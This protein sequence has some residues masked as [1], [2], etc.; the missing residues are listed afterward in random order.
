MLININGSTFEAKGGQTILA[1]AKANGIYIPTLCHDPKLKPASLCRICLVEVKGTSNWLPACSTLVK[2][3]M[4][5]QTESDKLLQYRRWLLGMTLSKIGCE[6]CGRDDP[7]SR[8]YCQS[9]GNCEL[10]ALAERYQIRLGYKGDPSSR[11]Y[12]S[13]SAMPVIADNPFIELDPNKCIL[14][15]RCVRMCEEVQGVGAY[16]VLNRSKDVRVFPGL[17]GKFLSSGCEFCGQCVSTCPTGA[18]RD[19]KKERV[20]EREKERKGER[21]FLS[22]LTTEKIATTCPHCGV[23][24][25]LFMHVKDGRL[26]YVTPRFDS[27]VNEGSLCIKGRYAYDFVHSS[28][29]LTD[30]LIK[31]NGS[32]RKATWDESLDLV[33]DKFKQ[34][35]VESGADA[36][37]GWSSARATNEANYLFQKFMR[38]AIGTNNIDNCART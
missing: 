9:D 4:E 27:P 20:G 8:L 23:G 2:P 35:K 18:L 3:S 37:V 16:G 22:P 1:V 13:A 36:I 19:R 32:F 5:I 21:S 26:L 30:P 29:R 17:E 10:Q 38:A 6:D 25:G 31:Q 28:E 24:C 11:P 12:M 14:C 34:I 33:A 7:T 15:M